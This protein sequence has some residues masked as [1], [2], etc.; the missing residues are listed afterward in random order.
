MADRQ[1]IRLGP[2]FRRDAGGLD[3]D[4]EA[5]LQNILDLD[6]GSQFVRDDAKRAAGRVA[7]DKYTRALPADDQPLRA[8]RRHCLA[9][10]CAADLEMRDQLLLG[11]QTFTRAQ[12][13]AANVPAKP[14]GELG[15]A[16]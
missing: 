9:H 3:L 16:A 5:K 8:E 7:G 11:R 4:R 2:P 12:L 13:S 14:L 1:K 15:R 10:H 6:E